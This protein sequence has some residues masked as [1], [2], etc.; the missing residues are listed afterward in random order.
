MR[1]DLHEVLIER[2]RSGHRRKTARGNKPRAADW[3]D[4][5]SYADS[6]RPRRLRT[7]YFDD[8]LSPLKRWLRSQVD[9]PWNKVWS[10]LS[11]G[12]DS[13]SV[14]GGH[15]LDHVCSL[16]TIQ[17]EYDSKRRA[18]MPQPHVGFWKKR[19]PV[20]GLYVDPRSG[21]LRWRDPP[22]RSRDR[23]TL[24][25]LDGDGKPVE[26]RRLSPTRLHLKRSGLWYEV[27]I[28]AL[29]P[30]APKAS[31]DLVCNV[32]TFRITRKRQLNSR[33]LT[34]AKLINDA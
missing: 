20:V 18:V 11:T 31:V 24:P 22:P 26:F 16:V 33:E 17:T 30:N 4:E 21:L 12:I 27:E 14:V 5:D 19:A 28:A 1:A 13:R 8:L 29:S 6:Y 10:E 25:L 15:L 32:Y 3:I 9:R 7:K 23:P 34:D 2:P